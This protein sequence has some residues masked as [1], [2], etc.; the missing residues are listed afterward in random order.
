MPIVIHAADFHIGAKFDFLPEELVDKAVEMQLRSLHALVAYAA[1]SAVDAV[2]IAGDLFDAPE[3]RPQLSSAVF[4]VLAKCPCPVFLSPGN[5]D[6]YHTGSPYA[7][8]PLP[9]NL[10]VFTSRTLEPYALDDG[11]TVI[12]GAAFQ[13]NKASIP[14]DA[15]L[16]D[17]K[18]NICLVHGELGGTGGYNSISESTVIGSGFDYIA[19]GH[20]HR[21]SGV[22]RIGRTA[23]SC[24]GCFSASASNETGIKGY[25]AGR[26][27]KGNVSLTFHPSEA[28]E[29]MDI[30]L[31]MTGLH[32]DTALAEALLPKLPTP[33][34]RICLTVHLTGTRMYN[35]NLSA[36]ARSLRQ[37]FFHATV[38]DESAAMQ[39]LY[40][41][42]DDDGLRG[43]VTRDFMSRMEKCNNDE[44]SYAKLTLALE[45]ALAALDGRELD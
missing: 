16:D 45:Y 1:A 40:R 20:N 30:T 33:P 12:W 2:L 44:R 3:V 43:T 34:N 17:T 4:A 5:H 10:H 29:F 22:F 31:P 8:Q 6:Y 21:F 42:Q 26:L 23:L 27:E 11:Q 28:V 13:D 24:P 9:A 38:L 7:T 36:L 19:L 41:Y 35:P 32:S 14:L 25:L 39:D 18:L 37:S 15:P